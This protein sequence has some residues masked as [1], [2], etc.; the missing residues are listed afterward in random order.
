M[1]KP[2]SKFL[3]Y[4][5]VLF[6]AIGL[7]SSY[8][9][10]RYL[11][12]TYFSAETPIL[13]QIKPG[14]HFRELAT[15][16]AAQGVITKP[17]WWILYA[18]VTGQASKV[19]AGEYQVEPGVSP[20][21]LLNL[22]TSGKVKT[23]Q[24][25]LVE[26][27]RFNQVLAALSQQEKLTQLV[28]GL[29]EEEVM[30]RLGKAGEHP[31]GRFFPDSYQY[32]AGNT[33]IDIL[34]RAY[35]RLEQVLNEEWISRD[36]NLPYRT[37]YEALIMASIVE[38]ET[39]VPA[40]REKIAGVFVRRL[41]KGMRLQTDPTVIYGLGD[42]YQGNL[43]RKHLIQQS[44]YNTYLIKG[45]PPTPIAMVG[46]AAIYAALHPAAGDSL[47]FVARGDGSHFFSATL[48]EHQKAVRRFQ[49]K[50]RPQQYKSTPD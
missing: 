35:V 18:V 30:R 19:K 37:S 13:V 50:Q 6:L 26:G 15:S 1:M 47:Y 44:S 46:R 32:V 24:V 43:Q 23:Y 7:V 10:H 8:I 38:K 31:E 21:Q 42:A 9:L 3:R 11:T 33:D 25:T 5:L 40:E 22:F 34:K 28:S 16:L 4:L 2:V 14:S 41:E 49:I 20:R 27:W 48:D 39:A 12:G 45:L 17:K 36:K 29:A